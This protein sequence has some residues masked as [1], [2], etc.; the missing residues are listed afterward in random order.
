MSTTEITPSPNPP[1]NPAKGNQ[2]G[3]TTLAAEINRWEALSESLA[4]QVDQ[5]PGLKEPFDQFQ[6]LLDE[7]KS[8]R[9]ELNAF[10][11]GAS[12]A[13]TRREQVLLD[14]GDLFSRLHHALQFVHGPR[15]PQLKKFGLKPLR[16]RKPRRTTPA[17]TPPPSTTPAPPP[18]E[19]G[20]GHA[21]TAEP[22][23]T[24]AQASVGT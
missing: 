1:A 17:A 4:P 9:A 5:V 21:P 16:T 14:G 18:V 10:K 19:V 6:A 22:V 12:A 13:M 11:A 15:N 2:R 23:T 7:A 8:L 20:T 3:Q 24:T